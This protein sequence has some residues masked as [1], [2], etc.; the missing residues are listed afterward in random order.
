M[1]EQTRYRVTGS[2]FLLALVIISFPM[3]FDGQGMVPLEIEPLD[4]STDTPSVTSMVEVA[5]RSDFV[6][7]VDEF[8]AR[9][10]AEGFSTV[11]GTHFGEP[12]LLEANELTRAWA[13]QVASF[14]EA[15]NA[16][17]LRNQLREDGYE[18]FISTAKSGSNMV[19]RV[20]V[21]PL[22]NE[23]DAQVMQQELAAALSLDVR[24]V[25]FSN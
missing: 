12:E 11:T 13:V 21:G 3:I 20:A 17:K 15:D 4:D 10:D 9:V 18:A 6:E 23:S 24:I 16:V 19:N 25:E 8:R 14:N 22:L 1:N 5:P 2:L 7:R